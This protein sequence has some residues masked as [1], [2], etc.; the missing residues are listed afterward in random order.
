MYKVPNPLS[1]VTRWPRQKESPH[2]VKLCASSVAASTLHRKACLR[3]SD[4]RSW[5]APFCLRRFHTHMR[6]PHA[7]SISLDP[8]GIISCLNAVHVDWRGTRSGPNVLLGDNLLLANL[9]LTLRGE[10]K[11]THSQALK[12]RKFE[13]WPDF[14]LSL[15]NFPI[16]KNPMLFCSK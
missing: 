1:S 6:P 14:L 7:G 9:P 10:F 4:M 2:T 5:A 16:F 3:S 11:I 8:V 13:S 15:L 12:L